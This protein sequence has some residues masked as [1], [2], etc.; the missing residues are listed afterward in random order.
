[1]MFAVEKHENAYKIVVKTDSRSNKT[2][3]AIVPIKENADKIA[4]LLNNNESR[5]EALAEVT[6]EIKK[7]AKVR[8]F[9]YGYDVYR[10]RY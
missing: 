3:I 8:T 1:M 6:N 9:K 10:K 5:N 7:D 4:L 2:P